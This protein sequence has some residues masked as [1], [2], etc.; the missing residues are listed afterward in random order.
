MKKKNPHVSDETFD[1]FLDEL[2]LLKELE[3]AA[4]AE[5][6]ARAAKAL[7]PR[8]ERSASDKPDS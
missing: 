7:S 5:I 4:L 8:R 3:E 1:E 6:A 2:G